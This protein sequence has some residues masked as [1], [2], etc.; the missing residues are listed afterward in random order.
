MD[1]IEYLD[2][3]TLLAKLPKRDQNAHKGNFGHV[4]VIGGDFGYAGAPVLSALGALRAGAGLVTLAT[5]KDNIPG[6]NGVHP[7]IMCQAIDDYQVLVPLLNKASVVVLGPGLGRSEWSKIIYMTASQTRLPYVL[8]AD[9]LYF[10]A[11]TPNRVTNRVLTPHPGEAATL[12]HLPI[13][14]PI[15]ERIT[16]CKELINKYDGCIVLKGAHTLVASK[17]KIAM[18][19]AGNPGMATA[20]MGDLLSGIIG[21][22]IAQGLEIQFAAELA[23]C[24]HATAG[25]M[26]AQNGMRGIIATDLLN[27]IQP[28]LG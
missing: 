12:L 6:L 3:K 4:L 16:A 7:E 20:G 1:N 9:S 13:A 14:I 23:V 5:H 11:Q 10:L 28:L 24:I 27:Y 19:H 25:D 18:C 22:L 21:G 17:N 2:L 26:A 8:D 15:E